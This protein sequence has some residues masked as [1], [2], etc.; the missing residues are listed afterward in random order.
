MSAEI[1]GDD[2]AVYAQTAWHGKGITYGHLLSANEYAE[3]PW[4][5]RATRQDLYVEDMIDGEIVYIPV[6]EWDVTNGFV[7]R[8]N[9]NGFPLNVGVT[10][11][12]GITQYDEMDSAVEKL[13]E[14]GFSPGVASKGTINHGRKAYV[15]LEMG[16]PLDIEGY[17]KIHKYFTLTDAHDGTVTASGRPTIGVVVCANT[18][19]AYILGV[20]A[21]WSVKHTRN[22]SNYL[23]W[24]INSFVEAAQTQEHIDAQVERLINESYLQHEFGALKHNIL[25]ERPDEEGRSQTSWD[26]VFDSITARYM[27]RDLDGGIR[28]TKW[29]ALMAVQGYEQHVQQIRGG[30]QQGRHL[31]RLLFG[32]MPLTEKAIGQLVTSN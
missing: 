12:R 22:A 13:I 8:R 1:Y 21:T 16:E 27:D 4:Q 32:S 18:F 15:T 25:G 29:G 2:L 3:N 6:S 28:E 9:D 19:A 11:G 5:F 23:E 7:I 10:E 20:K 31:D 30:T 14:H 24:A 17:S 26:K